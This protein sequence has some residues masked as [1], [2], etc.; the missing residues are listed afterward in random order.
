MDY[1]EMINDDI[2]NYRKLNKYQ[3]NYIKSLDHDRKNKIIEEKEE[4]GITDTI[5]VLPI[6]RFKTGKCTILR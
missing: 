6:N 1:Y 2:R 4:F 3:V 5:Y